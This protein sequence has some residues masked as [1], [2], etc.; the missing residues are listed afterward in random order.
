MALAIAILA[1][2]KG[3]RLKSKR[4]KVLHSIGGKPLL[5]HVIHAAVQVVPARDVYVIIG[6]QAE[7]VRAIAAPTGV[8]F[9]QQQE[10][11][12]TGH[13]IQQTLSALRDYDQVLVLSGDVPL[14]KVETIRQLRDFHIHERAAMSILSAEVDKPF[15]YGRVLR[16]T[17]GQPE[18]DAIIE[19]KSL[20]DEQQNLREINSGIYAFK[21]QHLMSHIDRLEAD[22]AHGELYLTDM[23]KL[24][25]KEGERVVAM[26]APAADE[27]LGANTI[28]EMM[29]LDTS[30]RRQTAE[31]HYGGR[32]HH[33]SAAHWFSSTPMSP[34]SPTR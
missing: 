22:N 13:A 14:L 1:A 11:K 5:L 8:R 16:G 33:L 12:G 23:A 29:M 3:T 9:V 18:V 15:G 34:F 24:L 21:I 19:Q 31:R 30:L 2:G 25:H 7:E 32:R 20:S 28:A 26:R 17:P 6:H 27:I 10:Q 4:P